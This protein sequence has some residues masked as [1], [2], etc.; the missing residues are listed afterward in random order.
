[1]QN[2]EIHIIPTGE[3][4]TN[5]IAVARDGACALFDPAG[6]PDA[7]VAWLAAHKLRPAAI[8]LTHGHFDHM[9]AVA[10]LTARFNIPWF[11]NN[12]DRPIVNMNNSLGRLP[13]YDKNSVFAGFPGFVTPHVPIPA[14]DNSALPVS[15]PGSP[16]DLSRGADKA[17]MTD[18]EIL[19]GIIAQVIPTPGHTPGGV[20]FYL[21][22]EKLL[23][24]GDTL[25]A[26][27]VGRADMPLGNYRH[28]MESVARIRAMNLP[29]DT[30]IIPGHDRESTIGAVK[31]ENRFWN[32]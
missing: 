10:E 19:P 24:S 15:A 12:A 23:I 9:T 28:L 22:A 27:G 1:M 7:W 17:E 18:I 11:M 16:R 30:R 25:F 20:C 6:D 21:P 32:L 29:D 31:T 13:L 8:Y 3:L 14:G 2:T 5:S 4:A 26:D